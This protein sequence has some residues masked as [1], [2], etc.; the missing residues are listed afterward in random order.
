[1]FL[2]NCL[3]KGEDLGNL[4]SGGHQENFKFDE[5]EISGFFGDSV[6]SCDVFSGNCLMKGC[7][8]ENRD[9]DVF[10]EAVL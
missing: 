7:L 2:G 10:L 1:M 9:S 3:L 4:E 6:V 8:A 5:V